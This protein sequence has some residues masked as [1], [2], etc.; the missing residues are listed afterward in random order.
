MNKIRRLP[1]R[2]TPSWWPPMITNSI[3]ILP[4]KSD[5]IQ[6]NKSARSTPEPLLRCR[7]A[8][9]DRSNKYG[10]NTYSNDRY[11]TEG[12]SRCASSD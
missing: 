9:V 4:I 5:E 2:I 11:S 3:T 8:P 10:I 6:T 12:V 1:E 7:K